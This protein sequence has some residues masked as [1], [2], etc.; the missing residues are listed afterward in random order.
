MTGFHPDLLKEEIDQHPHAYPKVSIIIPSRNAEQLIGVTLESILAQEYPELE[1]FIIDA[2]SQDRTF[3]VVKSFSDKRLRL[4][5]VTTDNPFEMLNKGLSQVTG[6]YINF[7]FPGDIYI[8]PQTIG[9]SMKL[10]QNN[11]EPHLVWG[12]CLLRDGRT[13]VKMLYRPFSLPILK[14]GQQPTTLQA[15][16]FRAD[17]FEI[18]GKFSSLYRLR[19]GFD[20]LCRFALHEELKAV[21]TTH[22]LMDY[23]LRGVTRWMVIQHFWDTLR[24]IYRHFGF[25]TA[26]NWMFTQKDSTRFFKLWKRS[27]SAAFFK[28]N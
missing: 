23:D 13:E 7:L 22:V 18:L 8:H 25:L 15:C 2:N 14:N 12:A 20:L 17:V 9:N 19:G 6:F 4:I 10:A 1:V 21:S 16:W 27:L 11:N 28:K 3:Q 5:S 26:L 24:I